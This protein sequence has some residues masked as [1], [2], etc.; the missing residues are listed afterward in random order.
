MSHAEYMA[1]PRLC[2]L[3]EVTWSPQASRDEADF[4]RRLDPQLRR[5]D[6]LGVN[7][8]KVASAGSE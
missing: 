7:Y 4:R 6:C 5:F 8:H 2:A 1:F 3:S